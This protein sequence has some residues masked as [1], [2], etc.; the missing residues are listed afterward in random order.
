MFRD[1][2]EAFIKKEHLLQEG[3]RLLVALSGGADS[4][5]LLRVL[6][7]L[8]YQCEAAHC[9]FHL[10]GEES[11]RDEKF[12]TDLCKRFYVKLHVAHFQT[13][14]YAQEKGISIEM[15]ARELRYNWFEQLLQKNKIDSVCV[16]HHRDDSVETFLLNLLRGTGINGLRGI[17]SRNRHV[18]RPLLCV[19]RKEIEE[20]LQ[21]HRQ[22]YVTDSTNLQTDF[23]RN[24]VRLEL[25]PLMEQINPAAREHIAQTACRLNDARLIYQNAVKEKLAKIWT[26]MG[27]DIDDLKAEPAPAT[28]L[29][30]WLSPMGFNSTQVDE[31]MQTLD[32]QSGKQFNSRSHQLVKDRSFLVIESNDPT[33]P[34]QL[35]YTYINRTSDF[36]IPTQPEV[37]C[38]DADKVC[39]PL[40]LRHVRPGDSFI[41][42]GMR[43]R[44]NV[45]DFLTDLK[46]PVPLKQRQ[47]V[48]CYEDNIVWVVGRRIDN[49]YKIK[50]T[51]KKIMMIRLEE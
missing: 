24:K 10:R 41:P 48:L 19:C 11:D 33:R 7:M 51:T 37:A 14:E 5:A 18:V 28:L 47:W 4:V 38:L 39:E 17:P 12:V 50:P 49:R 2:V 15:A 36:L 6:L 44:K 23:L 31:I 1:K 21:Y 30:E 45:N 42:L 29:Y 3:D 27:I 26:P 46:V 16:A 13:E 25:L 40:H 32:G 8:G 43:G 20:F 9:N 35:S 34:P 22:D